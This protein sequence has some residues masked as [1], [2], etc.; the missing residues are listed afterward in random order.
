MTTGRRWRRTVDVPADRIDDGTPVVIIDE[1]DQHFFDQRRPG[2]AVEA[3]QHIEFEHQVWV[4]AERYPLG[5]QIIRIAWRPATWLRFLFFNRHFSESLQMQRFQ[6]LVAFMFDKKAHAKRM[7]EHLELVLE[8]RAESGAPRVILSVSGATKMH[9]LLDVLITDRWEMALRKVALA[10]TAARPDIVFTAAQLRAFVGDGMM[11]ARRRC[12]HYVRRLHRDE[13]GLD[14]YWL[15]LAA[16]PGQP[17]T[18]GGLIDRLTDAFN[19]MVDQLSPIEDGLFPEATERYQRWM[20]VAGGFPTATNDPF[21]AV[22]SKEWGRAEAAERDREKAARNT[23]A[24]E[25]AEAENAKYKLER[26]SLIQQ[27]STLQQ[28]DDVEAA[29]PAQADAGEFSH[30]VVVMPA[31]FRGTGLYKDLCGRNTQ[32]AWTTRLTEIRQTLRAEFPHAL[33]AIDMM[34]VD[35]REDEPVAFRPFVLLG[36]PGCGKSRMVRRLAEL[37]DMRLRRYDAAGSSD[38]AFAGTPKRW[39]SSTPCFPLQCVA[40]TMIA[41]PMILIDEIDKAGVGFTAGNLGN[42]LMPF[43]EKETSAAYPDPCLEVEA[44]L[45]HVCYAMTANDVLKLPSPLRDRLRVIKVPSPGV[46]HIESLSRSIMADLAVEMNVPAAFLTPLAPDELAVVSRCKL[47]DCVS[48]PKKDARTHSRSGRGCRVNR[49]GASS[50]GRSKRSP[51]PTKWGRWV[52]GH[53]TLA[54]TAADGMAAEDR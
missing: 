43:L 32:L 28:K 33:A 2:D 51:E 48:W 34:L 41:N 38:N 1:P 5:P 46:E 19:I 23:A 25:V 54:G 21:K 9:L 52:D 17:W 15:M 22:T 3:S 12:R 24:L 4:N 44:D 20:H 50:R 8:D 42:A 30:T 37:L 31:D 7:L 11:D 18:Y 40:Q 26:R 45:S 10:T 53:R 13:S 27:L 29:Q 35:L 39:H 36:E 49:C 14:L 47:T 16:S 6:A